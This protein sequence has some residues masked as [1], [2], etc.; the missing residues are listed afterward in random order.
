MRAGPIREL[1][2]I[3]GIDTLHGRGDTC[4]KGRRNNDSLEAI[5]DKGLEPAKFV[6]RCFGGAGKEFGG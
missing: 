6:W 4:W 3:H 2:L 5:E 1:R